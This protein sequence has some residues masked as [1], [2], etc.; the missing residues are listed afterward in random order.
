LKFVI[1][2]WLTAFYG[3]VGDLEDFDRW[4]QWLEGRDWPQRWQRQSAGHSATMARLRWKG[5]A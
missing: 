3:L 2:I 5:F 4:W 1:A